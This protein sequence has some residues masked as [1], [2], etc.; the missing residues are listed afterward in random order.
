MLTRQEQLL[1]NEPL[2]GAQTLVTKQV[3]YGQ[4]A[5]WVVV[6]RNASTATG[7]SPTLIAT[8]QQVQVSTGT[9]TAATAALTT[10]TPTVFSAVAVSLSSGT[11]GTTSINNSASANPTQYL[12]VQLVV[13]GTT[14]VFNNVFVDL[15]AMN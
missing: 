14:P 2:V 9:V 4:E 7:T 3:A 11:T 13:G 5:G 8:L 6:V 1:A 10:L 15:V 12:Q